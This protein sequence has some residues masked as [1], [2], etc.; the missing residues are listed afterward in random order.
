MSPRF[1]R[2]LAFFVGIFVLV[3]PA[4]AQT[5]AK[6]LETYRKAAPEPGDARSRIVE[7][8]DGKIALTTPTEADKSVFN[9][10]AV[11]LINRVTHHEYHIQTPEPAELKPR[12]ADK[13]VNEL[14]NDIR[15]WL[16]VPPADG[17]ITLGQEDYIR[18]FGA[19]LDKPLA[20]ILLV[21]KGKQSP[22]IIR[23]NAARLLAVVCESGAPAHWP[24]VTKLLASSETPPEILYYALKAAEGLLGGFDVSRLGRLAA[25][26]EAAEKTLYDLVRLLEDV[27]VKGPPILD[28]LYVETSSPKLATDPKGPAITPV[29]EQLLAIQLYRLQAIRALARL[30]ND[31]LGGK[32]KAAYEVRPVYTLARVAVADPAIRPEFG[33]KEIA[34]AV[35]GLARINPSAALNVDEIA[36]AMS[37]GLRGLFAVKAANA[38]DATIFWK[39]YAG[40]MNAAFQDWQ[41]NIAKNPRVTAQKVKD[42]VN[43]LA[44]KSADGVFTPVLNATTGSQNTINL[45]VIDDWQREFP[46]TNDRQLFNDVKTF[47]L[48]YGTK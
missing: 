17:K 19:A 46:P 43:S 39:V 23:V 41:A 1:A 9:L 4:Q 21:E 18:E 6:Q 10:M 5:L 45:T 27:I 36:Y 47:K 35:I 48:T 7:Y 32:A 40:R 24:T 22:T 14:V 26:P 12:P 37:Y 29:P 25:G 3:L 44:K 2:C 28:H 8:R 15:K 30:R 33:K 11:Y 20:A 34:E 31:V 13:T 16:L 38:E 42:A